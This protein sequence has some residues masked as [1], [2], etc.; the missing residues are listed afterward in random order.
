MIELKR[1]VNELSQRL[2]E[3]PRHKIVDA[4]EETPSLVQE[5]ERQL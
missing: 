5:I 4:S 1:E 3:P 2:G